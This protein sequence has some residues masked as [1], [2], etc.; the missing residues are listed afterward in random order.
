M[1]QFTGSYEFGGLTAF[2][3]IQDS[4]L[5]GRS[6]FLFLFVVRQRSLPEAGEECL[7]QFHPVFVDKAGTIDEAATT[8]AVTST[9]KE[10]RATLTSPDPAPFFATARRHLE[11]CQSIWSWDDDVEFLGLS[12]VEFRKS[13]LSL[14]RSGG[15][16][17]RGEI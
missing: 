2:R 11:E 7:F 14:H 10:E 4:K 15:M 5:A 6:G 8:A 13:V 9:A 3:R 12:W 16:A 1:L 17:S